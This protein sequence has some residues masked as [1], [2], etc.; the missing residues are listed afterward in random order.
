MA[1][2]THGAIRTTEQPIIRIIEI[3]SFISVKLEVNEGQRVVDKPANSD[4]IVGNGEDIDPRSKI[5]LECEAPYP[6]QWVYDGEGVC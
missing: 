1:S 3:H 2:T 4:I 5:V 6:V